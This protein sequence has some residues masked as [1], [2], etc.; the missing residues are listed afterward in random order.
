[1]VMNMNA[2]IRG[3]LRGACHR[4]TNQLQVEGEA[5][6]DREG[7]PEEASSAVGLT[8]S[9]GVGQAAIIDSCLCCC[10]YCSVIGEPGTWTLPTAGHDFLEK[11]RHK[12]NSEAVV[13]VS[14]ERVLHF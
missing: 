4:H 11:M 1:M 14:L 13:G 12:M 5:S 6:P 8:G 7:F 3:H 2:L 9:V 10:D